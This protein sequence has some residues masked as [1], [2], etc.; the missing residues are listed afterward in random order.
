MSESISK[1]QYLQTILELSN[2]DST[3]K[4][5]NQQIAS[6][7]HVKPASVTN[8]LNKLQDA[9]EVTVIP[10]YGV[11]L[12]EI[13][14]QTALRLIRSHRLFEV[15]LTDKLGMTPAQAHD[16]ADHLDHEASEAMIGALDDFLGQPKTSPQGLPIPSQDLTYHVEAAQTLE[17]MPPGETFTILGF[18][19]D[20]ALLDYVSAIGL[21][22]QTTWRMLEQ[23]PFDGPFLIEAL[24][25]GQSIQVTKNAARFIFVAH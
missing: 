21:E 17:A 18:S 15:F 20:Q 6:H 5:S 14:R 9:G 13:G 16:N 8:M 10:Y 12:T 24:D 19:E 4:I 25:S 3:A 2:G 22:L 11:T 1:T 23:L 7:L